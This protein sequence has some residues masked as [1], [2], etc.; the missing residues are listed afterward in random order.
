MSRS[1][2]E[3]INKLNQAIAAMK[4]KRDLSNKRKQDQY[5]SFINERDITD[6][7]SNEFIK[8]RKEIVISK[9]DS[10]KIVPQ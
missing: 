9:K 1:N 5:V 3:K 2:H 4:S 6:R 7:K 8:S 10:K